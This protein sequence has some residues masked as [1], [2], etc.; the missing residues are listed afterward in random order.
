MAFKSSGPFSLANGPRRDYRSVM[1]NN[2]NNTVDQVVVRLVMILIA[3]AAVVGAG[4]L[5]VATLGFFG[6]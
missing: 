5:V 4:V 2:T 1:A 6:S 3:F